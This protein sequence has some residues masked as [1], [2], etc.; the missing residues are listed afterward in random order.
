MMLATSDDH[1]NIGIFINVM[2]GARILR[3]VV[4][5]LIPVINV[6]KPAICSENI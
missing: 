1:V 2:P 5:I 4:T 6:P 3:M